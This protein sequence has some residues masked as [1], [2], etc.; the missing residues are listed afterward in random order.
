MSK[1]IDPICGMEVDESALR[2]EGYDDVA[3]CSEGCRRGFLAAQEDSGA[4]AQSHECCGGHGGDHGG[5]HCCG[6]HG[7]HAGGHHNH[8]HGDVPAK[9]SA[10]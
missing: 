10:S 3:F 5:D 4:A 6:G 7:E 2:V 1:L 8:H 9:R